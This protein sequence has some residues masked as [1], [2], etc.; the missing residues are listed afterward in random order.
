[1]AVPQHRIDLGLVLP[2]PPAEAYAAWTEIE[3]LRRWFGD[4][5]EADIRV[6]GRYRAE[7]RDG[8]A[9]YVHAGQYLVLE[10]GRRVR[11]SFGVPDAPA[12]EQSFSDEFIE[13]RFEA[14]PGGTLLR[15]TNGWNG[16]P[17][18]ADGE[19]AVRE[20][21]TQWLGKLARSLA[22]EKGEHR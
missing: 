22:G 1:M 16:D 15:F 11:M 3:R 8:D 17:I 21:W 7:N 10:P 12:A 2:V 6:G 19:A 13:A 9:V 20:A 18:G 14:A 4:T 5:V